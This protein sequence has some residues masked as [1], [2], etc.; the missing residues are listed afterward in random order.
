M[1]RPY[2]EPAEDTCIAGSRWICHWD[3]HWCTFAMI[4]QVAFNI[5]VFMRQQTAQKTIRSIRKTYGTAANVY[6]ADDSKQALKLRGATKTFRL[7]FDV[8]CSAGRNH[9][10][11]QTTEPYIVQ[12]DD[13]YV[14]DE[15]TDI[16]R[17][18]KLLED[19]DDLV[20][21]GCK[22]RHPRSGRVGWTKYYADVRIV[23]HKM[24]ADRPTRKHIEADGLKW[25]QADVVSNFW[26]AKRRLFD[27]MMWDERLKIGGEHADF[28][29]RL[30]AANGDQA[31][32]QRVI[33][34]NL[35]WRTGLI[36][37]SPMISLVNA[38]MMKVAFVPS[39]WITHNKKRPA[40]YIPFRKRDSTFEKMH[41]TMWEI[42]RVDRW[43]KRK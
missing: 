43:R 28:F 8:G 19:H 14:F 21:V 15:H 36:K 25:L 24:I 12:V 26:V 11:R 4:D 7:P 17:M 23:G 18:V 39:L 30:Q 32:I 3:H 16:L 34:L 42:S 27:V 6:V 35:K 29:L 5:K 31:I 13:D 41:R 1:R 40:D 37:H 38:G 33:T 2:D 20:L 22:C 9:L 10:V